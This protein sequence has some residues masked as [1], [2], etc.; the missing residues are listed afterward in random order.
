MPSWLRSVT[1]SGR[2]CCTGVS[3]PNVKLL[4]TNKIV[5]GA[6]RGLQ[7]GQPQQHG[8]NLIPIGH[9]F[10]GLCRERLALAHRLDKRRRGGAIEGPEVLAEQPRHSRGDLRL[11]DWRHCVSFAER[12]RVRPDHCDPDVFRAL[13]AGAVVDPLHGS[14]APPVIRRNDQ[15]GPYSL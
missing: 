10:V 5:F 2:Y 6:C 3:A 8:G 1:V 12:R 4:P 7:R 13:L 11:S 14:T 15:R 9:R